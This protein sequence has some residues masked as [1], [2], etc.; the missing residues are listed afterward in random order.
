MKQRFMEE[1]R[2]AE[3]AD[4]AAP[5][6][7]LKFG[8]WHLY[9]GVGPSNLQTLGNF[10]SELARV[11]GGQSFHVSVHAHNP[12]GGF[13]SLATWPECA[14]YRLL[15]ITAAWSRIGRTSSIS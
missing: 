8:H 1:Y 14:P 10:A 6:V 15:V 5:R 12:A 2:R 9:R 3:A 4:R 13:R 11:N 7:I